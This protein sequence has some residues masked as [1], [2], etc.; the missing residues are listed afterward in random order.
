MPNS[1]G[2]TVRRWRERAKLSQSALG[3]LV[4]IDRTLVNKLEQ[5]RVGSIDAGRLKAIADACSC[6]DDEHLAAVKVWQA[7]A[8]EG[9]SA[10]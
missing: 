7:Q 3:A 4:G 2:Q 5:D 10:A 9:E 1:L 6:S 8:D